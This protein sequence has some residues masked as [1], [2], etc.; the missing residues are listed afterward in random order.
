VIDEHYACYLPSWFE[1]PI[2]LFSK[3]VRLNHSLLLHSQMKIL[4][5]TA[6]ALVASVQSWKP[7][8]GTW[9]LVSVTV[10]DASRRTAAQK[11]FDE[12]VLQTLNFNQ[13]WS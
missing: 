13:P 10:A 12:V 9:T 6:V 7:S 5:L 3:S 2:T 4:A 8:L 1:S 11:Y